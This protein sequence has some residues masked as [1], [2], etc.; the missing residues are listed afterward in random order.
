MGKETLCRIEG[1]WVSLSVSLDFCLVVLIMNIV[2]LL[3]LAVISA[4]VT[5]Q[6]LGSMVAGY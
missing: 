4:L 1:K 2:V 6:L 5:A 3:L